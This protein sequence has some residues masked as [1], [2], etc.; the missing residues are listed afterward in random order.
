MLQQVDA[1][2]AA[3]REEME[4]AV[5]AMEARFQGQDVPCPPFWG[6]YRVVGSSIEFWQG[7]ENRLH[8]RLQYTREGE[9]WSITRLMP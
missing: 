8:D 7:R 9:H 3:S 2:D 4:Q 5:K 1:I 6:G